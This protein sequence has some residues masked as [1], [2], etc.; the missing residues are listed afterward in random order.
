MTTPSSTLPRPPPLW[1]P[2]RIAIGTSRSRANAITRATSSASRQR[3]ISA[4]RLSIIALNNGAGFVVGGVRRPDQFAAELSASAWLAASL[5]VIVLIAP[6]PSHRSLQDDKGDPMTRSIPRPRLDE[7]RRSYLP[8]G[9]KPRPAPALE[10]ACDLEA[11]AEHARLVGAGAHR[12]RV[13]DRARAV[14]ERPSRPA[15]AVLLGCPSPRRRR[16]RARFRRAAPRRGRRAS[17]GPPPPSSARRTRSPGARAPSTRPVQRERSC[18]A[19]AWNE[20]P[21]ERSGDHLDRPPGAIRT[22]GPDPAPRLLAAAALDAR[23]GTSR[24][25]R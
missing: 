4:G 8:T 13:G 9:P 19:A 3:A 23:T 18:S 11:L 14:A 12:D 6:P 21:L 25:G 15:G 20:R 22:G 1:P 10:H 7:A 24:P 16:R 2:P 5:T 17:A